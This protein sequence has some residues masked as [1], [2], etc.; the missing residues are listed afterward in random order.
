MP[1]I[2]RPT[3]LNDELREV[4]A[5]QL[6]AG[7]YI[8]TAAAFAGVSKVT[9][10]DWIRRGKRELQRVEANPRAKVRKEEAPFVDFLN[11]VE[12]AQA[13]AEAEDVDILRRAA[14][15]DWKAAAW[16]LERKFPD[17]WGRKD[18]LAAELEHAGN[19]GLTIAVDYGDDDEEAEV[20]G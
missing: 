6:R 11:A 7:N 8:E 9:L 15:D 20:D 16:R 3:K 13:E 1:E 10:Y 17:K 2:G 5:G 12:R 19:V 14:R 18:R 4:I